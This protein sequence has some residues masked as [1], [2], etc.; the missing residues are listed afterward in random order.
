[1]NL[2]TL[3]TNGNNGVVILLII[4]GIFAAICIIAFIVY[5]FL[6]PKLKKDN[7]KPT[8]AQARQESL[9]RLL[10]PI[11]DEETAKAVSEY[12]EKDDE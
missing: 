11:D 2:N 1:M 4:I 5:R 10:Q 8:E 7:E 6:R 12:K 9:D 3:Q